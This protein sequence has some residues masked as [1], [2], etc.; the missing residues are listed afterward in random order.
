MK[1]V[2][3]VDCMA[4]GGDG[5]IGHCSPPLDLFA[6]TRVGDLTDLDIIGIPVWFAVRPNS[7]TLSVS[8]GKGLTHSQARIS[9]IMESV[10]SAVAEQTRE[11]ISTFGSVADMAQRDLQIVPLNNIGR[12]RYSVFSPTEERAWVRG[13]NYRT[14]A[15]IFAPYELVGLDLR[16]TFPWDHTS[17]HISSD[18]LAAGPSFEFAAAA[19]LLELVER[20]AISLNEIFGIQRAIAEEVRWEP[21]LHPPLDEAIGRLNRAGLEARFFASESR[22]GLPVIS[23]VIERPVLDSLGSGAR[24]SGGHACRRNAGEAALAALLEAVQS[25]LTNIAGSRDD[26]DSSQYEIS[27]RTLPA[28]SQGTIALSALAERHRKLTPS[29]VE[30]ELDH[31]VKT[32]ECAGHTEIFLFDL[33][34][35]VDGLYVVRALVPGLRAFIEGEVATIGLRELETLLNGFHP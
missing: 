14:R 13:I 29:S 16:T 5:L 8:Q 33:P 17:F 19:A 10:E 3:D 35:P 1:I 12:C 34:T 2:R 21:D 25:R 18:G 26:I 22:I 6:I 27:G 30:S 31:I 24:L 23:A 20:D 4:E 32:L 15:E 11:I 28:I 9:A 7:R